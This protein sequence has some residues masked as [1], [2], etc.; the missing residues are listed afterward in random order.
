MELNLSLNYPFRILFSIYKTLTSFIR[1]VSGSISMPTSISKPILVLFNNNRILIICFIIY[2]TCYIIYHLSYMVNHHQSFQMF[3]E[4]QSNF[5]SFFS[6]LLFFVSLSSE[7]ENN[8]TRYHE[9]MF[10]FSIL[11][12]WSK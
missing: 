5:L 3:S 12:S 11:S 9:I 8:Q 1:F 2:Q 10:S 4:G 6:S 7:E